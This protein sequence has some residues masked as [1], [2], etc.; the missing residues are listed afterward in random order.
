MAS[1][2]PLTEDDQQRFMGQKNRDATGDPK[3]LNG[4]RRAHAA[5]P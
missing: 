1:P 2:P 3:Q 4:G 5:A